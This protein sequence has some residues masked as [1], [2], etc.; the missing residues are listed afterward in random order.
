MSTFR[1]ALLAFSVLCWSLY[2]Q[3]SKGTITGLVSDNSG[4]AVPGTTVVLKDQQRNV[5]RSATSNDS[6]IYRFDAVDPGLYTVEF[7]KEGFQAYTVRELSVAA[8]QVAGVD[9]RL[10]VGQQ[11]TVVEVSADAVALQTEQP[12]RGAT[13]SGVVSAE[14]PVASR[15]PTLLA[16]TLPGVSSNRGGFGTATFS[17][18]GGRGRSNNFMLDGT[19]NNDISI[20]GQAFQ[21]TNPDAVQEVSVQTSNFDAEYGRAGGGVVNTIIRSGTNSIHGSAGYLLESTRFNAITNTEALSNYVR[22]N[23]KPIPGTDQWFSGTVGGPIRKDKLFYFAAFQERR[24]V[25]QSTVNLLSLSAAGRNTLRSVFPAGRSTNV[26][27]YLRA[28][29]GAAADS[30]FFNL[31]LGDGRPDVQ[32]GTF[33]RPI[34]AKIRNF[35]PLGKVDYILSERDR[36]MGRFAFDQTANPIGGST[37]FVGLDTASKSRYQN[38]ALTWSRTLNSRM[39]NEFRLPYNRITLDF[40]A[41]PSN[42]LGLTLPSISFQGGPLTAVGVA[43]NIPQGR[44]A[45]NYGVQDTFTILAGRHTVRFGLDLLEQRARQAAPALLRGS[46]SFFTGGGF[47]PLGNFVDNF[48]GDNGVTARDFGSQVYYPDLFRQAYFAQD[49]IRLSSALTVSLGI[50]YESFGR[51][52]NSLIKPAYSG[53]FNVDPVNFTGPYSQ[54]N[55]VKADRNNFAPNLGLAYSPSARDGILG[56]LLGDRKTSLRMGYM[57]GYESFFN[58]IA[59]NALASTPNLIS[60][61]NPGA[62]STA[63]PRGVGNWLSQIPTQARLPNPLD[64]QTL[65]L[66]NLVNPYYQRGNFSIQRQLPASVFLDVSYVGSRGVRLFMNED[67][68]PLVPLNRR[69]FPTGFTAASFPASRLQQ[70]YDPLQGTRTIRTN[71]GSS[72]YHSLQIEA[73]RRW[74]GGVFSGAYTWS[75]FLDNASDVF[76]FGAGLN[77]P[78]TSMVPIIFGGD[79]LERG[80]SALDRSHRAVFS[81]LYELPFQKAQKGF[82]GKVA[83]GWQISGVTTFEVGVPFTVSNGLDADG[84]SGA[85]TD[86]PNFNPSG[87]AGVRAVVNTASSTGYVNPD[88]LGANG[89]PVEI[90]ASAARYIQVPACTNPSGCA[91]GNLGRNTERSPGIKNFN[92]NFAKNIQLT[93]RFKVQFRSEMFNLFN[94]P[95]YG[96]SN[97]S[98]FA[99]GTGTLQANVGTAPLGR[100]LNPTFQDGGSRVVR[101]GLTVR[102]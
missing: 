23:Q 87:P 15:N 100:F 16:L 80:L 51:P 36:I 30:Q 39:T 82:I 74:N 72:T 31:P 25:S 89:R 84:L 42:P 9:A 26:D 8:A 54:P 85:G 33:V 88:V 37:N 73:K 24:Q 60:T 22:V 79:R 18:N 81:Y 46:A 7:K 65:M 94:T 52:M 64:A 10:E 27:T 95:Q 34:P 49:R 28:T 2:A 3:S 50:R 32:G 19:E 63:N 11:A 13:V 29:E 38:A 98:A 71:G 90:A 75:K 41:N 21:V 76:A 45:N 6:G 53:L 57:I 78:S 96:S 91:P 12:V 68:N 62:V 56:K 66:E 1:H 4:A 67:A 97:A 40:P 17:V 55:Q 47:G 58:N 14:L 93:E 83:G 35:Q 59:S 86:R 69:V 44:I 102:F 92:V 70:R 77:V 43:T 101:F 5:A 48:S 99:P 20:N 61:S